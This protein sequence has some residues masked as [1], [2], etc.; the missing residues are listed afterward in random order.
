MSRTL[1]WFSLPANWSQH[2]SRLGYYLPTPENDAG[3]SEENFAA[4]DEDDGEN[5]HV[6]DDDDDV[7]DHHQ[8]CEEDECDRDKK[9]KEDQKQNEEEDEE[10]KVKRKQNSDLEVKETRR[11]ESLEIK[12]AKYLMSYKG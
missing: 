9:K 12:N 7:Y 5:V 10:R 2:A 1:V 6:H 4:K 3:D 11:E 8:C